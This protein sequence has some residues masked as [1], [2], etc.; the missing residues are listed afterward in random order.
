MNNWNSWIFFFLTFDDCYVK[1]CRVL[2]VIDSVK[3]VI[4]FYINRL[5]E[6]QLSKKKIISKWEVLLLWT[7]IM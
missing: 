3:A 4:H 6:V 1:L 7:E 5:R 2:L